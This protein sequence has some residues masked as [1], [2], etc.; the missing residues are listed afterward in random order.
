MAAP[1]RMTWHV[2]KEVV[3]LIMHDGSAF[4]NDFAESDQDIFVSHG[5]F[6]LGS[7]DFCETSNYSSELQHS[8]GHV[9]K[10]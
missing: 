8:F 3:E 2:D 4:G 10:Q 5:E 1:K 6:V 7:D 9:L